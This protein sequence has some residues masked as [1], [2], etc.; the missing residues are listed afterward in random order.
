MPAYGE[1]LVD[2]THKSPLGAKGEF[3]FDNLAVGGHEAQVEFAEG[4]CR[5]KLEVPEA[6]GPAIDVGTVTCSQMVAAAK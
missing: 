5:F 1:L 6:G 2:S 4:V 3:W